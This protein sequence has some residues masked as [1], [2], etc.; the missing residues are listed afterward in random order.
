MTLTPSPFGSIVLQVCRLV[1]APPDEIARSVQ[2]DMI[3]GNVA[4]FTVAEIAGI[5]V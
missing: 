4:A 3:A 1:P 5:L 2:R